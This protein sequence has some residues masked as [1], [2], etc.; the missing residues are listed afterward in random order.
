M[1]IIVIHYIHNIIL[2]SM[3]YNMLLIF[4]IYLLVIT[5]I[6]TKHVRNN[7]YS[8]AIPAC[9]V[10][11]G[12]YSILHTYVLYNALFMLIYYCTY[13]RFTSFK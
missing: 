10:P 5:Q 8:P 4:N 2:L 3:S 11:F 6:I 12:F 9:E 1:H 7:A 13:L